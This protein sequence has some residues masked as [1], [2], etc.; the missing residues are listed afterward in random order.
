MRAL[1]KYC[2]DNYYFDNYGNLFFKKIG[3]RRNLKS[4]V[5]HL[6]KYGYLVTTIKGKF[7]AVHRI[8]WILENKIFPNGII[9]HING[10]R[11]DNRP[12]NLRLGDYKLNARN[13]YKTRAGRLFGCH[14]CKYTKKWRAQIKVNGKKFHL[15]RFNT[16]ME[17]HKRFLEEHKNLERLVK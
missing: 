8:I 11:S 3:P 7:M 6:N 9:D 14:F 2:I 4:P 5:G 16:E 13:T 15:G 10:N 12:I 17:A 1:V